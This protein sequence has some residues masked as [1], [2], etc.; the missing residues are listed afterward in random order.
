M[1]HRKKTSTTLF[2]LLLVILICNSC[3][4]SQAELDASAT[5]TA[6]A[7]ELIDNTIPIDAW[8]NESRNERYYTYSL[9]EGEHLVI[10]WNQNPHFFGSV[11]R[12]GLSKLLRRYL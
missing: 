4:P 2:A 1:M 3:G 11:I 7:L 10:R 6:A 9:A 12:S 8:I 5:G